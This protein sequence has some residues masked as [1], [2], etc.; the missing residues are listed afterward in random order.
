MMYNKIAIYSRI[1]VKDHQLENQ[2]IENQKKYIHDYLDNL[3]EFKA[4]E[5]EEY[6]DIGFS[7]TSEN[8]PEFKRLLN[9]VKNKKISCI[10]VKDLSRFMRD[11]IKIGDYLENIFP[12]LGVRFISINDKYDN[13]KESNTALNIDTQFKSLLYD[14]YV[15]DISVKLKSA[16]ILRRKKGD[17]LSIPPYGY[18]KDPK[19]KHKIIID[20]KT[21]KV[22]KKIFDLYVNGHSIRSI[23]K[24]L[25]EGNVI[26]PSERKKELFNITYNSI[27]KYGENH[28]RNVW[29]S[30]TVSTILSNE[31]YTGTY[32]FN[33]FN[34]II[35]NGSKTIQVDMKNWER[36]Y[37]HHT[38]IISI[39]V[40]LKATEKK[41]AQKK[42]NKKVDNSGY[43]KHSVIQGFAKC[44]NCNH[45]M[46]YVQNKKCNSNGHLI[47]YKYFRCLTCK[48]KGF[49]SNLCKVEEI[50][51]EVFNLLLNKLNNKNKCLNK[52]KDNSNIL[53]KI[54]ELESSIPSVFEKYKFGF[55]TK[56]EFITFK[57][58]I[59]KKID[60]LNEKINMR[61]YDYID[62]QSL[63][64]EVV[65]KYIDSI[66]IKDGQVFEVIFK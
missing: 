24:I 25:N 53:K 41:A 6:T 7:G 21:Y 29:M 27:K 42:I 65:E 58:N 37:N 60:M 10:I 34:N 11:Y 30:N 20:P 64:L 16:L 3:L 4:Y 47:I 14:F 45:V 57:K 55:I 12:F 59:N 28:K 51:N 31:N 35:S 61:S 9:D 17:Y 63:S 54:K 48:I 26:T 18:M 2:S 13:L 36:I 43:R 44:K 56:E 38:P 15:K 66:L 19:Y 8:R 40:F 39:E 1:S 62:L 52:K 32:V 50:E 22:V 23:A 33:R 49:S 46:A 5:R